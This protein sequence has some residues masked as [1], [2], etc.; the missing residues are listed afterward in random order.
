MNTLGVKLH[1]LIQEKKVSISEVARAI[2]VSPKTLS[3]WVGTNARFP[4]NPGA[5]KKMANYFH[6]GVHELLYDEQ[7]PF[8]KSTSKTLDS[9]TQYVKIEHGLYEVTLKKIELS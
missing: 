9:H 1:S 5:I 4:S 8:T 3:E 2:E 6:I 7:D